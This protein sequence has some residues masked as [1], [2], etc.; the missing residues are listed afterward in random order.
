MKERKKKQTNKIKQGLINARAIIILQ[1][2]KRGDQ[3][4]GAWLPQGQRGQPG[5]RQ[6]DVLLGKTLYSNGVMLHP[7]V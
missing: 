1:T 7:G 2:L 6:C 5:R 4:E 3:D